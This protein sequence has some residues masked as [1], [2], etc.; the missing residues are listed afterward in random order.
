MNAPTVQSLTMTYAA[1]AGGIGPSTRSD[2]ERRRRNSRTWHRRQTEM[3]GRLRSNIRSNA[4]VAK[5]NDWPSVD[6]LV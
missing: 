5:E 6:V 1:M 4:P 2:P 3:T